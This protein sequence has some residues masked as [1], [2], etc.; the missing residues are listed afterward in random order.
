M[1][2]LVVIATGQV[3][4][5]DPV[6]LIALTAL[7]LLASWFMPQL[8]IGGA[9]HAQSLTDFSIIFGLILV[10]A[11]W[12]V[13]VIAVTSAFGKLLSHMPARRIA[14]N[15]AKDVITASVAAAAGTLCGLTTPFEV[16]ATTLGRI[17]I[18][19]LI[20]IAVDEAISV[21][22]IAFA[23]GRPPRDVWAAYAPIRLAMATARMACGI[24]AG[25]LFASSPKLALVLPVIAVALHLSYTNRL[26]QRVDRL[27]WARMSQ[28]VDAVGTGDQQ[29]V[30]RSA[31]HG[32]A[33]LF[34]CSEV[35][36]V[37]RTAPGA[38]ILVRGD[39]R[40][41]TYI[42]PVAGAPERSGVVEVAPLGTSETTAE[43]FGELRLR[44]IRPISFTDRERHTLAALAAALGTAI[45]KSGAVS[46]L[47][48]LTTDH[49][50]AAS[51]DPLTGLANRSHLLNHDGATG[52]LVGLAVIDL[53]GFKQ[54][55]DALG[56]RVGD[57]VLMAVAE[58]LAEQAAAGELMARISVDEFAALF[59]TAG[60]TADVIDRTRTLLDAVTQP[61]TVDD[62]R[63]NIAAAAGVA[64]EAVDT[65]LGELLRRADIAVQQAKLDGHPIAT[66]APTRDTADVERLA[67]GAELARAVAHRE[68]TIAF[69]PV[70]DL[71]TGMIRSAEAL[72]R[73]PHPRLGQLSPHQFLD[74]I[75]RSG[76]LAGF[77][78]HV[79]D[80]ALAGAREWT[81]A[82]FAV[83]VAVNI[84]PRSL[85]DAGFPTSIRSALDR[86]DLPP[87]TLI[88]ELTE[89][90]TLSK[91]D[92]V[93]E[94]L[95]TLRELGVM[96]ALDD[97]GTGYSSLATVTRVTVDELKIDR[98]F[99]AGLA[100]PKETAIVRTT[101]ELGR[102][103]GILVVAEGIENTE[104]RDRLWAL[105]CTAGQGHLFSRAVPA[106]RLV[107]RLRRGHDGVPGRFIAPLHGGEVIRL[108]SSRRPD[109]RRN[110][111]N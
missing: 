91:V 52:R 7:A 14:R 3:L 38:D 13:I 48:Q 70:I 108:P 51:H 35:D 67:L 72:A 83:P 22:A 10:P 12:L 19:A 77:T 37:L 103:L 78:E 18:V 87:R 95:L 66:F 15:V 39:D 34:A 46:A 73:W 102:A 98:S 54:I 82:G 86:Y 27:A 4:R 20:A 99:V 69:Q 42:G 97:F 32:T 31:V 21:P 68:F 55:D 26:Q 84:S 49:A 36:L 75:E 44:F 17:V 9:S 85:L 58:R 11:P 61:L 90:L 92:V 96:L 40:I 105:G 29:T 88:I 101:I 41:I 76:L 1:V 50:R 53:T 107:E 43:P 28:L 71:E 64:V 62:V 5:P 2:A 94:V 33:E 111:I 57:R 23:S 109:V 47:A 60:S 63:L 8:R 74:D 6:D 25:Y 45:R 89:T 59:T 79:L 30:R 16:T 24:A 56:Q 106:D 65:D 81:D 80:R 93:D 104:Q 110:E 100:G